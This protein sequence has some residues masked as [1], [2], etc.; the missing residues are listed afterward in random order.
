MSS[1]PWVAAGV[2]VRVYSSPLMVVAGFR[3]A[4]LGG[5]A[6]QSPLGAVESTA[7]QA[8]T[9]KIKNEERNS[10]AGSFPKEV[11]RGVKYRFRRCDLVAKNL[12]SLEG[13][14]Q[15]ELF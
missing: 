8:L 6:D 12:S 15:I 5:L 2:A 1:T 3:E 7:G 11:A 4:A 13:C 9:L 10:G 14:P